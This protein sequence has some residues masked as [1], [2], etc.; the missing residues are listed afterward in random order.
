[1]IFLNT[2]ESPFGALRWAETRYSMWLFCLISQGFA[3]PKRGLAGGDFDSGKRR[4]EEAGEKFT[5]FICL[6]IGNISP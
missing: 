1:V 4:S 2:S 3:Y 5:S 6:R